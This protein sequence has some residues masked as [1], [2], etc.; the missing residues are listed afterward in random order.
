MQ[1]TEERLKTLG[2]ERASNVITELRGLKNKMAIAYEHYRAVRQEHIDRFDKK[3]HEET[4]NKKDGSYKR[5]VFEN[6]KE[7]TKI[8]PAAV[9]DKVQ[10]A[11]DRGCFDSL[12]V[13][14]IREVKDP[15]IFG[16]IEKCPDRFFIGQWDTDVS[17]DDILKPNEG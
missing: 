1:T 13:C 9:L 14:H 16:R 15:I 2:F 7:T 17:I 10:E 5:L 8:P 3:L 4:F 12:E 6:I 11:I